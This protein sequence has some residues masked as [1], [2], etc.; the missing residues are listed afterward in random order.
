MIPREVTMRDRLPLIWPLAF[1]LVAVGCHDKPAPEAALDWTTPAERSEFTSTPSYAQT[2]DYLEQLAG[3]SAAM[4]LQTFGA[5]GLGRDLHVAVISSDYLFTP[6]VGGASG[7]PVVL[8]QNGIHSGEIAGKDASLMLLR[9]LLVEGLYPAVLEEIVLL[10]VPVYNVDGHERVG[11][12]RINQDGPEAGMGFRAT[13]AGLDLNRDYMKLDSDEAQA[14]VRDLVVR[15]NPHMLVDDHTT[16]GANHQYHLTYA[17]SA[18]PFATPEAGEWATGC[19]DRVAARMEEAGRPVAPYLHPVDRRDPAS[20]LRGGFTTTRFSTA[21]MALRGRTSVLVEAHSLKPYRTRVEATYD[22]LRFLLEDIAANPASLVEATADPVALE[23][24]TTV[25]L[26]LE[27]IDESRPFLY[28]TRAVEVYEGEVS[29]DRVARY[30]DE[31]VEMEV[32]VRDQVAVQMSVDAPAGYLVPPQYPEVIRRLRLHGLR[33]C[34]LDE[35]TAVTAEMIRLE[36]VEFAERPYQGRHRADVVASSVEIQQREFPA[37]SVWVP[38]D[39]PMGRVALHLL[40]PSGPDS[41]FAWGFF[42]SVMER[43]EYFERYVMEPMAQQM[44]ADDEQLR[45]EFE[46]RLEQDEEFRDS[47]WD[48]LEFFYRRTEHADPDWRLYPVA[49]VGAEAANTLPAACSP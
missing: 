45:A 24:G 28:R 26:R 30:T 17:P 4:D 35:A 38:L 11:Q 48:R 21:Y 13:A 29:G 20:G 6:R 15:W 39:Q 8:I 36:E 25:P 42:S 49:R 31:F 7:K 33:A 32:P 34:P 10:V 9:D 3:S 12:S 41:Y 47:P 1:A 22:F 14:L 19:M 37:G 44:L 27:R 2:L 5:S 18:G 23:P 43:K 46:A 40:E 16:D